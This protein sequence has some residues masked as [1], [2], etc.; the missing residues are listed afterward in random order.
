MRN[1][2]ACSARARVLSSSRK[3]S[4]SALI[5]VDTFSILLMGVRSRDHFFCSH[6]HLTG[7]PVPNTLA[8]I[9]RRTAL[10]GLRFSKSRKVTRLKQFAESSGLKRVD[11]RGSLRTPIVRTYHCGAQHRPIYILAGFV[12]GA[13]SPLQLASAPKVHVESNK[14]ASPQAKRLFPSGEG[15]GQARATETRG[16]SAGGRHLTPYR[17]QFRALV[18]RKSAG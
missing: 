10:P 7:T 14:L 16:C 11:D 12:R 6:P 2:S 15:R 4:G 18:F 1:G 8:N 17:R 9:I 13:L 5:S 3:L